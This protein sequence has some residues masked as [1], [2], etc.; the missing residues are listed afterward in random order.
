MKLCANDSMASNTM[1]VKQMSVNASGEC[2]ISIDGTWQK[3]CHASH[4]RVGTATSLDT[5]KC[6]NVEVIS[7]KCQQCLKWNKKQNDPKYKGWKATHQ[8]KINHEGVPTAWKRLV[9]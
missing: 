9:L 3:R 2:G 6:L 8:C 4:N 5:K 1:N 7:E